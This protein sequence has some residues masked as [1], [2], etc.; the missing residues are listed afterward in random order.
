M[1]AFKWLQ[2]AK[3]KIIIIIHFFNA[4]HNINTAMLQTARHSRENYGVK[5]D[6]GQHSREDKRKMASTEDAWTIPT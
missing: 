2:R 6:K 3:K 4:P 5:Q 1:W